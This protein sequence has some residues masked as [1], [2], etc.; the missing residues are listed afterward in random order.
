MERRAFLKSSAA[1]CFALGTFSFE[2]CTN[3]KSISVNEES[4][5]LKVKK[6]DFFDEKFIIVNSMSTNAPIYLSKQEENSY[7]ALL[8]LCTHKSCEVKPQGNLLVCPCHGSEFANS[9]KVLKEP[10][11][12]DLAQYKTSFD[13]NYIYIYLK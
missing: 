8:M 3:Y 6:V 12:K 5:K 2:G 4:G 7:I 13:E 9:G 10:A 11:D 1:L